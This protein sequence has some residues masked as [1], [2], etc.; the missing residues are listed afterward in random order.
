M[1]V[2]IADVRAA[3]DP[4]EPDYERAAQLG[5]D[6]LP[7][8]EHLIR[9]AEPL[10]ASKAAYLAS[11]ILDV[12]TVDVLSVAFQRTEPE[13]RVAAVAGARNLPSPEADLLIARALQDQDLGVRK[14]ALKSMRQPISRELRRTLQLHLQQESNPALRRFIERFA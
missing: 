12:S 8:L 5:P 3:L 4:E 13:V 14:V 7:H 2:T 9:T 11:L 1:T 10:L 6:A